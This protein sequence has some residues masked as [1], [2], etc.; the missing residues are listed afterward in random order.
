MRTLF[1]KL[2]ILMTLAVIGVPWLSFAQTIVKMGKG[3]TNSGAILY[4]SSYYIA[5]TF[6][7]MPYA[8]NPP[9]NVEFADINVSGQATSKCKVAAKNTFSQLSENNIIANQVGTQVPYVDE[10]HFLECPINVIL[11][12]TQTVPNKHFTLAV[13]RDQSGM[14]KYILG[15]QTSTGTIAYQVLQ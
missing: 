15:T 2:S 13:G 12:T 5:G 11:A 8:S 10:V 7:G 6:P 3:T 1:G 9:E 14:T 4:F